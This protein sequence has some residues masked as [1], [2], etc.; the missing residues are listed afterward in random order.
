[1]D[2]WTKQPSFPIIT[3]SRANGSF[4]IRQEQFLQAK[5]RVDSG[6]ALM[7]TSFEGD[8]WIVPFTY[9][10]SE[11]KTMQTVWMKERGR[12]IMFYLY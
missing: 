1:M 4:V 7:N 10:T 12:T 9:V 8:K 11:N 6:G 5:A 3:M 2:T